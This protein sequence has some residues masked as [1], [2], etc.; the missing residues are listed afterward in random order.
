MSSYPGLINTHHHFYQTLTRVLP[1]KQWTSTL[2]GWLQTLY[3]V[4][5][6]LTPEALDAAVTVALAELLLSGCTTTTD[7]HYVF[8]A[9]LEDA[10]AIEAASRRAPGHARRADPRLDGSV[11]SA[12][13]GCRRIA[14]C[15]I[16][17]TILAD[18]ARLIDRAA[19][20]GAARHAA[21]RAGTVL[22]LLRHHGADAAI[23][24]PWPNSAIRA[25]AY[26][27]GRNR[28]T[29]RNSANP[30]SAARRWIT[31]R[32]AAGC[33]RARGW[34]MASISARRRHRPAGARP[35]GCDA[36]P[37]QQPDPGIRHLPGLR[38]WRR[39]ARRWG[40]GWMGRRPMT[41]PT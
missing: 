17:D 28:R 38:S 1:R 2:F 41:G 9:G 31:W 40:W 33:G 8:P 34:P 20:P 18:S 24:P 30:A 21:D 35:G 13:A 5:A 11:A 19:R 29:R 23:P 4:W 22:A 37:V 3:P 10:I 14:W 16:A 32:I 25:A 6:R 36:L 12:M 27:F 15:R 39:R 26:A 7:H